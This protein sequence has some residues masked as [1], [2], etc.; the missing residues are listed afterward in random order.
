MSKDRYLY[1]ASESL[2]PATRAAIELVTENRSWRTQREILKY[3]HLF[4]DRGPDWNSG[5]PHFWAEFRPVGPS[6][7][8]E[9]EVGKEITL[10]EMGP[11]LTDDPNAKLYPGH[12]RRHDLELMN[13]DRTPIPVADVA[14]DVDEIRLLGYFCRDLAELRESAFMED[15]PGTLTSV[16][17][18]PISVLATPTLRTAVSDDELRSFVTIFRRLYMDKEPANFKK[19]V[20]VYV[21]ALGDHPIG[22]WIAGEV[23]EYE[24]GLGKIPELIPFVSTLNCTFTTKRLVDVFIYTQYAHQPSVERQRQYDECLSQVQGC[25]S[26]LTWLFLT[27]MWQCSLKIVNAG[28]MIAEWFR[29]Y[30]EHH[31]ISPQVLNSLRNDIP[32]IGT[33]EKVEDRQARLFREKVEELERTL[34][35]NAG[36]PEGGPVQFRTQARE[37]LHRALNG[38]I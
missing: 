18:V 13:A 15:G 37:Q 26:L 20:A 34:W 27:G 10:Y 23:G 19:A 7:Y 3:R 36:R 28:R 2:D 12:T 31:R 32:G 22:K 30:C 14:L 11:I 16:G 17:T 29:R 6:E 1:L 33:D 4:Q 24:A 25:R 21:R 35:I 8:F 9:D 5:D 38:G